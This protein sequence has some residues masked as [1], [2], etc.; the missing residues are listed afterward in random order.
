MR[1][2]TTLVRA[3]L[4]HWLSLLI[5]VPLQYPREQI[6]HSEHT[7]RLTLWETQRY[8]LR[9]HKIGVDTQADCSNNNSTGV[10]DH[11]NEFLTKWNNCIQHSFWQKQTANS[12]VDY[13]DRAFL[14][15]A[16]PKTEL[17]AAGTA[18][19]FS[20][21]VGSHKAFSLAQYIYLYFTG[22][23]NQ[24]SVLHFS[25]FDTSGTA[26][27]GSPENQISLALVARNRYSSGANDLRHDCVAVKGVGSRYSTFSLALT[28]FI[29]FQGLGSL[30]FSL[31]LTLQHIL[32][33]H[34]VDWT[35][36]RCTDSL[37]VNRHKLID[38]FGHPVAQQYTL[39]S[40]TTDDT[41]TTTGVG[42]QGFT[43]SLALNTLFFI[44]GV[45]SR[46]LQ[47][48]A[49]TDIFLFTNW[50]T[51]IPRW[52]V[53]T[54]GV[55]FQTLTGLSTRQPPQIRSEFALFV[56][57]FQIFA[58]PAGYP[59]E[60]QTAHSCFHST[61][62]EPFTKVEQQIQFSH[63]QCRSDK[64]SFDSKLETQRS[65]VL[66]RAAPFQKVFL[67]LINLFFWQDTQFDT[68]Q[69]PVTS[70]HSTLLVEYPNRLCQG[71]EFHSAEALD[72]KSATVPTGTTR[73]S[74]GPK[75]RHRLDW[76]VLHIC[77]ALTTICP[78]P[79]IQPVRS[80]GCILVM[81][82]AGVSNAWTPDKLLLYD[83]KTHDTRPESGKQIAWHPAQTKVVKRSIR[84][85]YAR[86]MQTGIAW[87]RG[88]CLAPGDFPKARARVSN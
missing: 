13:S 27:V 18:S 1:N 8:H 69:L 51:R 81:E 9:A 86:A 43:L 55:G 7:E 4:V 80:E 41:F 62:E 15:L 74:P 49:L 77:T 23:F 44:Q 10:Q 52:C 56:C 3:L 53:D 78:I 11:Y 57:D 65:V 35:T 73:C 14:D 19:I 20:L 26:G 2:T 54:F 25:T 6:H 31:A 32:Q 68:L 72:P 60:W 24:H 79:A 63:L 59:D 38:T 61:E 70:V 85:A 71:V 16:L 33:P 58:Q 82:D 87:Y 40:G 64:S 21:G 17:L 84:R 5:V 83:T 29:Y 47:F 67:V 36:Q 45:G 66:R 12:R 42:S 37:G 46:I 34:W 76:T 48:L 75:S 22:A 50:T 30:A 28:D 88:Q 39:S